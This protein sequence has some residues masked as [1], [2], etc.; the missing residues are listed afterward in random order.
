MVVGVKMG[1][2]FSSEDNMN[3]S[4]KRIKRDKI[5]HVSSLN[6]CGIL[7]SPFEFYSGSFHS[8]LKKLSQIFDKLKA[9]YVKIPADKPFSW[10][11]S[12][13]DKKIKE[14]RYCPLYNLHAGIVDNKFV[15][16]R[17]FI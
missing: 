8:D 7:K 15:S 3:S 6:Y 9:K 16:K 5:I 11:F 2:S 10:Q 1:C 4:L 14:K 12:K 17:T 13:L